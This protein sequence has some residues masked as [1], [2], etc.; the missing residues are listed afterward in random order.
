MVHVMRRERDWSG[1]STASTAEFTYSK[2]SSV[3]R[4][5]FVSVWSKGGL[6]RNKDGGDR[7]WWV[8]FDRDCQGRATVF[9]GVLMA[10]C[11]LNET[12]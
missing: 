7:E 11:L 8:V 12:I 6:H 10:P 3:Q 4:Y 1:E 9:Q 5:H 2:G